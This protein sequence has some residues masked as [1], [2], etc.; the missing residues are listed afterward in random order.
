MFDNLCHTPTLHANY[1]IVNPDHNARARLLPWNPRNISLCASFSSLH[2]EEAAVRFLWPLYLEESEVLHVPS[3]SSECSYLQRKQQA[4]CL[5]DSGWERR[6]WAASWRGR[7]AGARGNFPLT[8]LAKAR[9]RTS[10]RKHN[11]A[12]WAWSI[13]FYLSDT[14]FLLH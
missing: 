11:K 12:L 13:Q 10:W 9:A 4:G 7:G 5:S 1:F 2:R 6:H 8:S 3:A 14:H